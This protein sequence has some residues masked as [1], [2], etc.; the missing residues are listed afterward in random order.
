MRPAKQAPVYDEGR[1]SGRRFLAFSSFRRTHVVFALT[2]TFARLELPISISVVSSPCCC[3]DVGAYRLINVLIVLTIDE[4]DSRRILNR[5]R[6][7]HLLEPELGLK[8]DE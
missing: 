2:L 7:V 3:L 6:Q 8:D 5:L 4:Y 1:V